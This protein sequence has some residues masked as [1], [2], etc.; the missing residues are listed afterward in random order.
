LAGRKPFIPGS[1]AIVPSQEQAREWL[2]E[3]NEGKTRGQE[4]VLER[5]IVNLRENNNR[6]QSITETVQANTQQAQQRTRVQLKRLIEPGWGDSQYT[7]SR[8]GVMIREDK[9]DQPLSK[10][11]RENYGATPNPVQWID[12]DRNDTDPNEA[13]VSSLPIDPNSPK[14][15]FMRELAR[16]GYGRNRS[17]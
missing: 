4:P 5:I 14:A 16:M 3:W 9:N 11:P 6:S 13:R 10:I 17:Q 12:T 1:R 2:R 8:E 7:M 15:L